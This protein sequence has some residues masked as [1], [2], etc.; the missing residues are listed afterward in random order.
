M[1]YKPR[2]PKLHAFITSEGKLIELTAKQ[3]ADRLGIT[4]QAVYMRIKDGDT[5]SEFSR[6]KHDQKEVSTAKRNRRRTAR[7]VNHVNKRFGYMK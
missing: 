6:S 7:N 2:K 4:V 5:I 3:I 1:K